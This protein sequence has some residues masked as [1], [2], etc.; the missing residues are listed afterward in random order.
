M[1]PKGDGL[2]K[3]V[4][5]K[6]PYRY[7]LILYEIIFY[8]L[9]AITCLRSIE[10]VFHYFNACG[11]LLPGIKGYRIGLFYGRIAGSQ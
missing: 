11:Y 1:I 2:T 6:S 9:L 3:V 8:Y 5:Q 7:V 10:I 4:S